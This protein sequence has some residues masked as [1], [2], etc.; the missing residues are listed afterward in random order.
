MLK[1]NVLPKWT[2]SP[3][4]HMP[5]QQ[6]PSVSLILRQGLEIIGYTFCLIYCPLPTTDRMHE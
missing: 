4:V 5:Y 1:G 3:H 2:A 6:K